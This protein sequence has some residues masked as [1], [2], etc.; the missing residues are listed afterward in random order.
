MNKKT[1]HVLD[2]SVLIDDPFCLSKFK[3]IQIPIDVLEELD[4]L[5]TFP[6]KVGQNA[7]IAIK[8]IDKKKDSI[9]FDIKKNKNSLSDIPDNRILASALA[10]QKAQ[11]TAKIILVSKD[12]NLRLKAKVNDLEAQDYFEVSDVSDLY[13]GFREIKNDELNKTLFETQFG[14]LP[15]E[16]ND[17]NPNEYVLVSGAE[18]AIALCKKAKNQLQMLPMNKK[19]WGLDSKNK[20]Q[21]LAFDLLTNDKIP[22]VT[23]V[24]KAGCG[25]SLCALAAGL[26]AVLER[27]KYESLIVYRPIQP[28]GN[29][30]GYL[31][32]P[33]PLD[34]KIL[35]PNGW[36]TMG[37]LK[38]GSEV[39]ARDGSVSKVLGVFPKGVKPVYKITTTEE[40][41][42]ECCADHIWLTKTYE[43]KKRKTE[44]SLKTTQQIMETFF[45]SK[46]KLNHYL[47]RN[48][49]V[50]FNKCNLPL[51]PY[52]LGVILG[53]GSISDHVSITSIDSELVE[54]VRKEILPLDCSL[55]NN[56]K[57]ISYAIKANLFNNK[58]AKQILATN[59]LTGEKI[60]YPSIGIAFQNLNS[61]HKRKSMNWICTNKKI[62][63]NI[64]YEFLP[65]E[66]KWQNPIKE[67]LRNLGLSG[68]KANTKFIPDK[69]KYSS[70]NNRIE[71]LRGL[72]DTDGTIKT[73]GEAMFCTTSKQLALDLIEVVKSLGGRAVLPNPRNRVGRKHK[74]GKYEFT[75]RLKSYEF[76]VSLPKEINPFFM[77]RKASRHKCSYMHYEA[78]K[79]IDYVGEKEVQCIL[80]DN[81]EHLYITDNYIVT[82]NTE[83]E[84]LAPW[85][86]PIM[87]N[88]EVLL[89]K[90]KNWQQTLEMYQDKGRVRFEAMTYIR[91]R[92][93]NNAFVVFDEIQNLDQEQVKTVL[94]RVGFNTKIVFT[95]DIEQIDR[96]DL[97]SLNNGLTHVIEKFKNESL[98]GHLTLMKGERSALATLASKKL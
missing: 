25:K 56:G 33:Q 43:N 87:D 59:I 86:G 91:G 78:I 7:R 50:Q 75:T 34:A 29:D 54:K 22:L 9:V 35:T 67:I 70:I 81:P 68:T 27:K 64:Q 48:E 11:K 45:S 80:I 17:L 30:I 83:Q 16:L 20:E 97:D 61:Y 90:N 74:I 77:S 28:V 18:S 95:G 2:T 10:L 24:G 89:G 3:N 15:K 39:I 79:S 42:T 36:T 49:P 53:D 57:N 32:G 62:I 40:V 93:I 6:G 94:T 72:M 4:K 51:A 12:F 23:L 46:G 19:I 38:V 13:K 69:Y 37:E 52:T 84:K 92:S 31:P 66:K 58:T 73:R 21:A 71:L 96:N 55:T 82:H 44:G 47:P 88:M 5:K 8:E 76:T 60:I 98:A 41:A 26:E 1:Y 65:L 14:P 63:N 85:M